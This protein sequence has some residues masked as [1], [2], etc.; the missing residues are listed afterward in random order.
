MIEQALH[1][2]YGNKRQRQLAIILQGKRPCKNYNARQINRRWHDESR[3]G[4]YNFFEVQRLRIIRMIK[5]SN[6]ALS[7]ICYSRFDEF[8][9][10]FSQL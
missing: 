2:L 5:I 10:L 6:K 8:L 9:Y 3:R 4:A 1:E 7:M